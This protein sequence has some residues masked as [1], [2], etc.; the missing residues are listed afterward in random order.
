MAL[1]FIAKDP[2]SQTGQSP[3]AWVDDDNADMV[4]QG[5]KA[6]KTTQDE[7]QQTGPIPD[8]EAVIRIP[9]RMVPAIRKAC[10]VAEQRA[11]LR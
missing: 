8:H 10:D 9:A 2:N 7:C 6:D 11:R 4:F 1:R 3:S 5:W